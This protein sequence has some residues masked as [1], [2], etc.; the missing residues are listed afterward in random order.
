[1]G[2]LAADV[3]TTLTVA[4]DVNVTLIVAVDVER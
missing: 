2:M 1:M 4:V 3:N